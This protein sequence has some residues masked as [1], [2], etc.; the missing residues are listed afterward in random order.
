MKTLTK[1]LA[2]AALGLAATGAQAQTATTSFQVTA[3]VAASCSVAASDLGFGPYLATAVTPLDAS[4]TV[5][6]TCSNSHPYAVNVGATPAARTMGGPGGSVLNYGMFSDAGR[7]TAFA[8]AGAIGSGAAQAYTVYGRVPAGQYS[9]RPGAHA[10]TVT[11]TVT[12]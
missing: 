9:A 4:T 10:D 3:N 5:N 8:V 2:V 1:A 7:T 12:Y 6:V 11:V